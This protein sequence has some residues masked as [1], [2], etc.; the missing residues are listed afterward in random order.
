MLTVF[1]KFL[2][3]IWTHLMMRPGVAA[4]A[5]ASRVECR[6]RSLCRPAIS[7]VMGLVKGS[8]GFERHMNLRLCTGNSHFSPHSDLCDNSPIEWWQADFRTTMIPPL[9]GDRWPLN[10]M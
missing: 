10:R 1:L 5:V 6:I 8:F 2:L 4:S 3:F 9:F 7:P